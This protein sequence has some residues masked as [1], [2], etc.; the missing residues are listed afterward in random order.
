LN[1]AK[2]FK[3]RIT[4]TSTSM[5][6]AV[7]TDD[8]TIISQHFG[9]AQFYEVLSVENGAIVKRERRPK[10]GHHT[11]ATG[12]HDHG[13]EHGASHGFDTA[14]VSKHNQMAETI[15]DCQVV[16]A[17]GMGNGAYQGMLQNNIRPIVTDIRTIDEAAQAVINGT[18]IDHTE[19][20][21]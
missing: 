7:V 8:G 13:H 5:K 18:I 6:I 15:K 4:I 21:H 17:R 10:A 16:L 20:L 2:P 19:K 12:D 9:R 3:K 11:F 14:S 1:I